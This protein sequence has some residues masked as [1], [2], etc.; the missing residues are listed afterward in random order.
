MPR[1]VMQSRVTAAQWLVYAVASI[2]L[3]SGCGSA[4]PTLQPSA[5][6]PPTMIEVRE[7]PATALPTPTALRR[8]TLPPA[9][10]PT[11]SV[12]P[13]PSDTPTPIPTFDM[14][15]AI[16]ITSS[17]RVVCG[18]FAIDYSATNTSFDRT[19]NP[20]VTWSAVEDALAYRIT[21]YD[22]ARKTLYTAIIGETT[23]NF[24]SALFAPVQRYF[25][26]VRPFNS[27]GEQLCTAIGGLLVP[28]N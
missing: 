24:G 13:L 19:R 2:A 12:T 26:D 5:T 11:T 17:T 23:F 16:L 4:A 21:L 9:W 28:L 6:P 10:T 8:A 14:I 1:R 27:D 18:T 25:W 3:L 7:N 15:N 20:R 22:Q